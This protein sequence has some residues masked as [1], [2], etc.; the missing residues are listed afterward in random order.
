[1]TRFDDFIIPESGYDCENYEMS[2]VLTAENVNPE[3]CEEY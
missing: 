3:E 2:C 1:M